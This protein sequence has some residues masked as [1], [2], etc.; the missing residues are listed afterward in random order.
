MLW[1]RGKDLRLDDHQPLASALEQGELVPVFVLDPYF[2]APARAARIARRMQFLLDS[3]AELANEIARLGSRLLLV[4]GKSYEVIPEL[5]SRVRA[6]RVVAQRWCEPFA[7]ARDERVRERLSVPLEL[8]EGE[9]LCPPGTLRTGAGSPYTVFTA[10]AR[11][12]ARDS[13]IAEPLARPSSLPA[14]PSDIDLPKLA[15]PT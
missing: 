9:T 4:E 1:F 2:F 15:M 11:T 10:F 3:L 5:A 14:L 13:A 8:F 12:F 6:D 7:R